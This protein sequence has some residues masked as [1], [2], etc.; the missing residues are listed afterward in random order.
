[1]IRLG[2]HMYF[3]LWDLERVEPTTEQQT[4]FSEEIRLFFFYRHFSFCKGQMLSLFILLTYNLTLFVKASHSQNHLS[5]KGKSQGEHTDWIY[6]TSTECKETVSFT[7]TRQGDSCAQRVLTVTMDCNGDPVPNRRIR[8]IAW[9][10]CKICSLL[11]CRELWKNK[12]K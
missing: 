11:S 3:V 8:G 7:F 5:V 1:M 2:H 10:F 4:S 6:K 12:Y 9:H